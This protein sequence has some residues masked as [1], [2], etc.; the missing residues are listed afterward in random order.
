VS[1]ARGA[2]I[3]LKTLE[4]ALPGI[5]QLPEMPPPPPPLTEQEKLERL[6]R[7]Q[8]K[9]SKLK[10]LKAGAAHLRL[11]VFCNGR[12][13]SPTEF[14]PRLSGSPVAVCASNTN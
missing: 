10:V 9:A 1:A 3:D 13:R 7:L 6:Q 5:T 12:R 4:E 14:F 11:F 8:Q 2:G